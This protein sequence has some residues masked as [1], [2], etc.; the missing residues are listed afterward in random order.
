MGEYSRRSDNGR[1]SILSLVGLATLLV[2]GLVTLVLSCT[3]Y[4]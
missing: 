4:G 3:L 1:K 2:I